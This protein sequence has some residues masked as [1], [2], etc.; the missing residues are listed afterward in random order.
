MA[1]QQTIE[2]AMKQAKETRLHVLEGVNAEQTHFSQTREE[3]VKLSQDERS[4]INFLAFALVGTVLGLSPDSLHN[5]WV[6]IGLGIVL[7]NAFLFGFVADALQ[8]TS[9]I[10]NAEQ[11]IQDVRKTAEPYFDAYDELPKYLDHPAMTLD[12]FQEKYSKMQDA[13]VAYLE[14]HKKKNA[15]PRIAART[16][17]AIGYWYFGLFAAGLIVLG[18]GLVSQHQSTKAQDRYSYQ[19][20]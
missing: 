19:W 8:R 1:I 17:L 7:L 2:E 12:G 14:E 5:P 11:A 4:K 16:K 3:Q 10:R 6:V 18:V 15:K 13:Y 20:R 9:N